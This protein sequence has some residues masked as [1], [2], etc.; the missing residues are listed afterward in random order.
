MVLSPYDK[1][2][3][4]VAGEVDAAATKILTEEACQFLAILHHSFESTRQ[5]LLHQRKLRQGKFD[6]GEKPDFLPESKEIR[7]D[8]RWQGAKAA[9]GLADRRVEITGPTDRKMVVNALNSP[10]YAYMADFEDSLTPT[11]SNLLNGQVNLFDAIRQQVDFKLGEKEYKLR[12]DGTRP[13]LICRTRGWHLDE[14]HFL[15]DNKPI[16]GA[17]FDFGLYFFHNAKELMARGR[18]PYFYI[19][20]LENH[21]EAKLWNDVYNVAQDFIGIPRGTI[22]GTVLIETITA[23]FEMDEIIYELRDHIAGLNCGRWDYIFTFIKVFKN[24]P[25]FVLPDRGDITMTV[26]FMDAYVKLLV[27]TCHRR[28]IHAMGGMSALIPIKNNEEANAKA[29]ANVKADKLRE[30]LAGCDGTW[31]AHPALA[32][33]AEDV[34]NTYMP[35]ANQIF[36]RPALP[37][38]T[39][40]DLLNPNVTGKI[41]LAGVKS[42][43]EVCLV[44]CEA[45]LRGLGCSPINS[46]MEDAATAEISRSLLWQWVRHNALT[47]EGVQVD[48][49][50]VEKLLTEQTESLVQSA[51]DG[52][53]FAATAK[54]LKPHILGDDYVGFLPDP[55]ASLGDEQSEWSIAEPWTESSSTMMLAEEAFHHHYAASIDISKTYALGYGQRPFRTIAVGGRNLPFM[56]T[57][58]LASTPRISQAATAE[59]VSLLPNRL[60]ADILVEIYFE[61]VHWFMLLF[62]QLQFRESAESLYSNVVGADR[63]ANST[64]MGFIGVFLATCSIS[65]RLVDERQQQKLVDFGVTP[66]LLRERILTALRLRLLDVIG[67]GSL[68]AVQMCVLLGS[69]YLYHG[70]PELAWPLCGC[71]MRLGQALGLHRSSQTRTLGPAP[72]SRNASHDVETKKRCWWAIHEIETFCS[73]VYGS[74]QSISDADY[75]VQPLGPYTP[76]S[77]AAD[78]EPLSAGQTNLLQY[79]CSMLEL[80]KFLIRH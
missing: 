58:S 29:M 52:N 38:F 57:A 32:P 55:G 76:C 72:R 53:R 31:V 9:P 48:K 17:L 20:K 13:T 36:R 49:A 42:N 4:R 45:W 59:L 61:K 70:E 44:Y 63:R 77:M 10:V 18:G 66:D 22:R 21:L 50:L 67:L 35:T 7:E 1:S 5:Q 30:V 8:G 69:Y 28:G 56:G 39:R 14:K 71:A 19:P 73:M 79:K 80:S 34:F 2:R 15:V 74:P 27:A 75:D 54:H 24:H 62:H 47:S 64:E 78:D 68:E 33:L 23:V 3:Y 43:V 51:G 65:L 41:T 46:L 6:A 37:N 26:P 16:A 40:D 11:W 25:D 60:V 12:T